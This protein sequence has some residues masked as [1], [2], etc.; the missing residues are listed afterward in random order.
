MRKLTE[1]KKHMRQK[2]NLK[3]DL[4]KRHTTRFEEKI[5]EIY[6]SQK[7]KRPFHRLYIIIKI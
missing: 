4:I 7:N 3:E 2:A 1:D 5:Q 6:K